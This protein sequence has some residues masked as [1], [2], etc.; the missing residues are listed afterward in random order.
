[1]IPGKYYRVRVILGHIFL[2]IA[3]LIALA[4]VLALASIS[5]RKGNLAVGSWIPREIS[6]EHWQRIIQA[7]PFPV[8]RW[9]LNSLKVSL[10]ASFFLLM[11]SVPS[12]YALSRFQLRYR[13]GILGGLLLLQMF[14]AILASVAIYSLFQH[15]GSWLPM[16]GLDSHGGLILAYLGGISTAIWMIKGYF[17]R[18]SPAIEEAAQLDGASALH[19]LLRILLPTS[20]PILVTVFLLSFITGFNE[21][22]LASILLL[23]ENNLTLAVGLRFFLQ[24]QQ[25][26]WGDFAAAALLGGVPILLLF[27]FMQRFLLSGLT[28][29]SN[30]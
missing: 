24:D 15:L 29:G 13:S 14:P 6:W 4:P 30:K 9:I 8:I 17:E 11:L 10:V 12:A 23:Q 26:L 16:L 27:L 19:I 28:E 7:N 21:Y 25:F 18:L 3:V 1:M 20:Y 2:W 5:L 22:P